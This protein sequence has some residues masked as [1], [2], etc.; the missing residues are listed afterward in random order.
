MCNPAA[1]I[2]RQE[3]IHHRTDA[4]VSKKRRWEI[5]FTASSNGVKKI[6]W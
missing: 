4:M 6:A 2:F 5:L 1:L 3:A